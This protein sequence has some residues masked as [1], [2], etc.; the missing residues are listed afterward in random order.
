M[1]TLRIVQLANDKFAI[2]KQCFLLGCWEFCEAKLSY[3]EPKWGRT[4]GRSA[5]EHVIEYC[6]LDTQQ[7]AEMALDKTISALKGNDKNQI[8]VVRVIKKVKI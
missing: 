2:Q 1:T 3:N 5:P 6:V 7:E 8:K 4:W